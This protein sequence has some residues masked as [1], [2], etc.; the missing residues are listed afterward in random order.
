M[1]S[2]L[3]ARYGAG[4]LAV[5][6]YLAYVLAGSVQA[7][8]DLAQ[9]G[10]IIGIAWAVVAGFSFLFVVMRLRQAMSHNEL[11]EQSSFAW[12]IGAVGISA[13]AMQQ[14]WYLRGDALLWHASRAFWWFWLAENGLSLFL[15]LRNLAPR[16]V[17]NPEIT[18][19]PARY[20]WRRLRVRQTQTFDVEGVNIDADDLARVLAHHL[21][22]SNTQRLPYGPPSIGHSGTVPQIVHVQD[23][24]GRV[25]EIELPQRD[26]VPRLPR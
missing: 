4:W 11:I 19:S 13:Y 3:Q 16:H 10:N 2:C 18:N 9:A 12:S 14:G 7:M 20:V 26:L 17:P 25:I 15:Q 5:C 22:S 23:E 24:N 1:C 21:G 6:I 8:I